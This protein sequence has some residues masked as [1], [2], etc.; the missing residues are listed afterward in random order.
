MLTSL[1]SNILFLIFPIFLFQVF[2]EGRRRFN[3]DG[4]VMLMLGA[5]AMLLCMNFPV[6]MS[7]GY[8]FDFRFTVLAIAALYGSL[9]HSAV[10]V[11]VMVAY[12]WWMGGDGFFGQ[13]FILALLFPLLMLARRKFTSRPPAVRMILVIALS[14]APVPML[15]FGKPLI[16]QD[17]LLTWEL[18]EQFL[19]VMGIQA[20]GTW[21]VIYFIEKDI[22]A[23]AIRREI[24][25]AEKMRVISDLAASVSHEVRN[26]LT[27]ARGFL[28]LLLTSAKSEKESRFMTL[29]LEE[30]DRAQEII[31]DYLAYAKPDADRL[32]ELEVEDEIRYVSGVLQP[33]AL[34]GEVE[35]ETDCPEHNW[36]LGERQKFR[37]CLINLVKNSIEAMPEGG[38]LRIGIHALQN[39]VEVRIRDNG[40]GMTPEEVSRLGKAFYTT[41]ERGTGLGTMVAFSIIKAMNGR[42]DIH[43]K[44]GAGTEFTIVLPKVNPAEKFGSAV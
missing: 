37:Q 11:G 30:L 13:L 5:G 18:V 28:Q 8:Y 43:S 21:I 34:F 23:H 4:P 27:V 7:D 15:L 29:A 44:K 26:P 31:G 6:V 20:V 3:Q 2:W 19:T 9:R 25:Q 1:F 35:I 32:E 14:I 24:R 12:R 40:T 39:K 36:V 16:F 17:V 38:K 10:L 22:E 33:Y 41:K 42:I